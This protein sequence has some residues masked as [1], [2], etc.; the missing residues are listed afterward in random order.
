MNQLS[1]IKAAPLIVIAILSACLALMTNL[2]LGKRDELAG[3]Q[4]KV[5]QANAD[6]RKALEDLTV[7]R[8]ANLQ[9]VRKDYE[10]KVP[11]IRDGAVRAYCLRNPTLCQPTPACEIPASVPVDDGTK[12]EPVACE[13]E[14]IRAAAEDALK[15]GAWQDYCKRNNCPVTE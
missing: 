12:Q 8:E 7:Q 10:A 9:E 11:A 14:F 13:R 2:Y 1:F 6:Q 5:S 3:F 15:L 4:A